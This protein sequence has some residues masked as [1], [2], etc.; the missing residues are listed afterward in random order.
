MKHKNILSTII[1]SSLLLPGACTERARVEGSLDGIPADSIYL[2]R[3]TNEHYGSVEPVKSIAV[4]DGRF[5]LPADSLAAGL[6]CFSLQ[7][8]ARGEYIAQSANVMLEPRPMHLAIGK[9]RY[10]RLTLH[11]TGS[12]LQDRYEALQKQ[13]Y[14]AGNRAVLDSL[15]H[16]F[17]AAREKGDRGEMERIRQVSNPYYDSAVEQTSKL[18]GEEIEKNRGTFFG[19]YLYYMYRF[20]NHTFNTREEI[21]EARAFIAG[22]DEASRRSAMYAEVQK[23]LDKFALCATGSVAPAITGIGLKGDTLS[24]DALRGKYVLVDFWFAGCHWC[25]LEH[26]YLQKTYR[27][28]RD[29]GFTILGVS[30]DRRE[31]D[32]RKAVEEDKS[33]WNQMLLPRE[34]V[35]KVMDAYCIVGFPHIILVN[36][37]GVIVAKELRGDDLYHTVERFVNGA[38]R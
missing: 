1:A 37:E 9:D 10:G 2:Y 7:S 23:A 3:V 5:T 31:A 29:K 22:F 14:V 6:Y 32:W 30:T 8:M 25:R 13:K 18:L 11:A 38:R 12:D 33:D 16:L 15:D 36:P 26:P 27:A 21:A 24:L 28:F 35:Q 34:E 20:R 4:T 19:L 17:Y